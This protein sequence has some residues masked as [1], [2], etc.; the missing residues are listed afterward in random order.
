MTISDSLIAR[1]KLA[2]IGARIVGEIASKIAYLGFP[3]D[4]G[5]GFELAE[6]VLIVRVVVGKIP[7]GPVHDV[8]G[9]ALNASLEVII[10]FSIGGAI[11][12]V[13]ILDIGIVK[14]LFDVR[15]VVGVIFEH[16]VDEFERV[17]GRA[18]LW[19]INPAWAVTIVPLHPGHFITVISGVHSHG[20]A[21]LTKVVD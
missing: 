15:E 18:I 7:N 13:S 19:H 12:D 4:V 3:L 2:A 16:A 5:S 21:Q 20:K 6:L 1:R 17:R 11:I 14:T 9:N 10:F 8:A